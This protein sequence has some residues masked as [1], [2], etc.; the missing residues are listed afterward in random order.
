[1]E[2]WEG[3]GMLGQHKPRLGGVAFLGRLVVEE[4]AVPNLLLGLPVY[5]EA[6]LYWAAKDKLAKVLALVQL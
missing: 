6:L 3:V 1:L 5:N 2:S 4:L